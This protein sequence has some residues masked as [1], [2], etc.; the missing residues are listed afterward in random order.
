LTHADYDKIEERGWAKAV[1]DE[2]VD[3]FSSK[4]PDL[5][6]TYHQWEDLKELIERKILEIERC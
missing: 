5:K 1:A 4:H 6:M 3:A 2:V